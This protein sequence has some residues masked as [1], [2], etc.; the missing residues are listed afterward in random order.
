M[1]VLRLC[2]HEARSPTQA[3]SAV[4]GSPTFPAPGGATVVRDRTVVGASRRSRFSSGSIGYDN[5]I[6]VAAKAISTATAND[7]LFVAH[8]GN[9]VTSDSSRSARYRSVSAPGLLISVSPSTNR[10]VAQPSSAAFCGGQSSR[11]TPNSLPWRTDSKERSSAKM[12]ASTQPSNV[13]VHAIRRRPLGVPDSA[14]WV[15]CNP[16][17]GGLRQLLLRGRFGL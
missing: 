12:T 8:H 17:Q 13:A 11:A 9:R 5:L 2:V 16:A 3:Q 4:R 1:K 6:T 7:E 14:L 10:C 15:P